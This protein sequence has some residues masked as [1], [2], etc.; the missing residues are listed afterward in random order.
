MFI[1]SLYV[2]HISMTSRVIGIEI[3]TS[4]FL[5]SLFLHAFKEQQLG[6]L[7]Q[8]VYLWQYCYSLR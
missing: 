7:L 1:N 8:V 6:Q 4:I 3:G 2:L 5:S